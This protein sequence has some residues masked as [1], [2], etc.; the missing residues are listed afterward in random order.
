MNDFEPVSLVRKSSF[1]KEHDYNN[2][3]YC[4]E[5]GITFGFNLPCS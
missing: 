4:Y 2:I 3:E 5:Q 1:E